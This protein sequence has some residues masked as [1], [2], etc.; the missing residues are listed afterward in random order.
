MV[1]V[2]VVVIGGGGLWEW[3]EGCW[4]GRGGGVAVQSGWYKPITWCVTDLSMLVWATYG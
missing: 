2:V 1:V 3:Y 4:E